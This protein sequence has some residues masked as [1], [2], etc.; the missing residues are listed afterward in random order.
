MQRKRKRLQGTLKVDLLRTISAVQYGRTGEK[1][2]MGV[3]VPPLEY[4]TQGLEQRPIYFP[5]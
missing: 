5:S 3:R 2:D 4:L 1:L